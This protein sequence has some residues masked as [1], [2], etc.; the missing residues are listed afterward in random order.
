LQS[1]HD[2]SR[3]KKDFE[4][5]AEGAYPALVRAATVLCW[6][7]AD[8]ED[9]VQET[10]LRAFKSYGAFRGDSSFFTWAYAILARAAQAANQAHTKCL[11]SDY[12]LSQ[13]QQLPPVDW[14][15]VLKEDARVLIDAIRSLPTRQREMVTLHFLEDL[16][17]AEI[18]AA[19]EVSVGTVKATIF[20]ARASLRSALAR[21]GI[22]R[23]ASDVV[24]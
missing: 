1:E 8:A 2:I 14:A 23:K 3:R 22:G 18:A 5:A 13:P 20:E 12:A 24:P 21:K 11:P 19:L 9:V 6:S 17:Y 7:R 15:V 4:A 10:M 16:C